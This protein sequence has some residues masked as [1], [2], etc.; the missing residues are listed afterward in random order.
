MRSRDLERI[1]AW[2]SL[3]AGAIH[4][5]LARDHFEE[6]WGY[7]L[8]FALSGLVQLLVAL[9]LLTEAANPRD[10]GPRWL[11]VRRSLYLAGLLVNTGLILVYIV[12]RTIGV[13]FFGPEAGEV[14]AVAAIDLVAKVL[15]LAAVAALVAL[16]RRPAPA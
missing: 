5:V 16:L 12:S 2:A 9:A 6:W 13:P 4:G 3:A 11:Q 15:E 14:E 1:A 7:G 8:F 10:T